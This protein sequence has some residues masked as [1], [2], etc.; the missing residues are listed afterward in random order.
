M[1]WGWVN[2]LTGS[3]GGIYHSYIWEKV[4][5]YKLTGLSFRPDQATPEVSAEVHRRGVNMRIHRVPAGET[6]AGFA[7]AM[8]NDITTAG[9]DGKQ[10]YLAPNPETKDLSGFVLPML[11]RLVQLRPNRQIVYIPEGHQGGIFPREL[12]D[13]IVSHPNVFVAP[14]DYDGNM[15]PLPWTDAQ[16]R[17]DITRLGIPERQ[18][19]ITYNGGALTYQSVFDGAIFTFE[20]LP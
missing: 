15:N 18:V 11:E 16:L 17:Q 19:R 6:P 2:D 9:C 7:E 1:R 4:A 5:H 3:Y 10:C 8:S 14:E 12:I 20:L 13:F